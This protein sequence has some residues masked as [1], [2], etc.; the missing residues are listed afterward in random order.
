MFSACD[1]YLHT[2]DRLE[3]PVSQLLA[4]RCGPKCRRATK[5]SNLSSWPCVGRIVAALQPVAVTVERQDRRPGLAADE[6]RWTSMETLRSFRMNGA[7]MSGGAAL[8]ARHAAT[9]NR[10]YAAAVRMRA[11][12]GA[13]T[14]DGRPFWR[15]Q[16]LNNRSWRTVRRY[17][18]HHED[19]STNRVHR[20]LMTCDIP[21]VNRMDFCSWSVP[22]APLLDTLH[23]LTAELAGDPTTEGACHAYLNRSFRAPFVCGAGLGNVVYSESVLFCAMRR[24]GVVASGLATNNDFTSHRCVWHRARAEYQADLRAARH[25]GRDR[26]VGRL[27]T[28]ATGPPSRRHVSLFSGAVQ[29]HEQ[30]AT[31]L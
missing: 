17:A 27:L 23:A 28:V 8:V 30:E 12:V 15:D 10:T 31:I 21:R 4:R 29:S 19:A 7:S 2:W 14:V 11:D 6:R 13:D 22:A 20:Q 1:V 26:R 18:T 5:L 24:A 9:M 3:K 16:M 25:A